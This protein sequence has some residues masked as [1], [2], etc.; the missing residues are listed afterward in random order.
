[1]TKNNIF[2]KLQKIFYYV[3]MCVIDFLERFKM[4]DKKL[5]SE[6]IK[7]EKCEM[8]E[9]KKMDKADAKLIKDV[10]MSKSK[11]DC[12]MAKKKDD[13]SMSAKKKFHPGFKAVEKKIASKEGVSK[14][15]AGAILA[16][17]S[18]NASSKAKAAN[19]KLNKVKG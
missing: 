17:S 11:K 12:S 1:M 7:H 16:S 3:K 9:R 15:S 4:A 18:K 2:C 10:S 5:K 8:K 6:I 13:C 19:P 14:K